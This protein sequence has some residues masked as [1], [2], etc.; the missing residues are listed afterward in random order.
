MLRHYKSAETAR[1]RRVEIWTALGVLVAVVGVILSVI[2][3]SRGSSQN[4]PANQYNAQN[5][6]FGS[7]VNIS[8]APIQVNGNMPQSAAPSAGAGE[9]QG[10]LASDE[11]APKTPPTDQV[12]SHGAERIASGSILG[13]TD[14]KPPT[15][16]RLKPAPPSQQFL[17][18]PSPVGPQAPMQRRNKNPNSLTFSEV[19]SQ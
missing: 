13:V 4:H 9:R 2:F 3:G 19:K 11:P 1:S 14:G 6:Y 7:T 10:A 16:A 18:D 15:P 17:F 8:A 5:Q 12:R